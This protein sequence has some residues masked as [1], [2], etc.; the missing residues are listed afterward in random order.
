MLNTY[1]P[2]TTSRDG[3]RGM[4]CQNK[5]GEEMPAF[6]ACMV[7]GQANDIYSVD[8]PDE[9]SA[10]QVLFGPAHAVPDDGFFFAVSPYDELVQYDGTV[11]P[12][13]EVGTVDGEWYLNSSNSGFAVLSG[14]G[15]VARVRPFRA[16]ETQ[17]PYFSGN[18]F[19]TFTPYTYTGNGNPAGFAFTHYANWYD[20]R[21][22]G[23]RAVCNV[24]HFNVPYLLGDPGS[25]IPIP[26]LD[27]EITTAP[28]TLTFNGR[29]RLVFQIKNQDGT[30][31]SC[32]SGLG[33]DSAFEGVGVRS[34]GDSLQLAPTLSSDSFVCLTKE[35]N[36]IPS[37]QI[38]EGFEIDQIRLGLECGGGYSGS[39]CSFFV[40]SVSIFEHRI[41]LPT[42][43]W[44]LE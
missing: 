41:Q 21:F 14:S 42:S 12:G 18:F 39:Q 4:K 27:I 36:L 13:D 33:Y 32:R 9:D 15:G 35:G 25:A 3:K 2:S 34:V 40:R 17:D 7:T 30:I 6:A 26:L 19:Q 24:A 31:I 10:K 5:S 38:P 20:L 44:G 11:N 16:A 8:K 1:Q 23:S 37:D 22:D 28:G 29:A 43:V